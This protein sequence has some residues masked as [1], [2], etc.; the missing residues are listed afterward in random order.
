MS[1]LA[2]CQRQPGSSQDISLQTFLPGLMAVLA[3]FLPG[4]CD[5]LG[6]KSLICRLF[7][8]SWL[9]IF[10]G[11]EFPE[12]LDAWHPDEIIL[13]FNVMDLGWVWFFKHSHVFVFGSFTKGNETL[14]TLAVQRHL[15]ILLW[16]SVLEMCRLESLQCCTLAKIREDCV[17]EGLWSFI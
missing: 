9:W 7:G 13:G 11:K 2:W 15:P 6:C 5:G 1:L 4:T 14:F 16:T 8:R 10:Q 17:P 3:V 12:L